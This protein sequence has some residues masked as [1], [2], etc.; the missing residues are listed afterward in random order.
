[1]ADDPE[2]FLWALGG[3]AAQSHHWPGWPYCPR[4]RVLV[5]PV[6]FAVDAGIFIKIQ[7]FQQDGV[8]IRLIGFFLRGWSY[9]WRAHAQQGFDPAPGG[10]CGL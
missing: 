9:Q 8:D 6:C 3:Q 4:G 7:A 2:L 1:M 10:G 5:E